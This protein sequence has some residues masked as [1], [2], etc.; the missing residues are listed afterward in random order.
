M[1]EDGFKFHADYDKNKKAA[2]LAQLTALGGLNLPLLLFI[3]SS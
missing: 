1:V 2:G 3:P